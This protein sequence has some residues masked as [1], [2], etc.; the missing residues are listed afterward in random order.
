MAIDINSALEGWLI[1][2]PLRHVESLAELTSAEAGE[3]GPLLREGSMALR[4]VT[5]CV[6]TYVMQFAEAKDFPHVHFHLVPRMAD[7]PPEFK[8]PK[9]FGY[10]ELEAVAE[11]RRDELAQLL[12]EAWPA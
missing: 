2:A 5:G 3:L 7:Q 4:S 1:I 11:E 12:I 6:K 10:H 8:G 9:V